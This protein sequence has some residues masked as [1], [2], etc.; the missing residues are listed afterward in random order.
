MFG[1]GLPELIILVVIIGIPVG[2]NLLLR[3]YNK[4]TGGKKMSNV[5]IYKHPT[6]GEESV[7]IGFSWPAFLFTII[8]MLT[9]RL[10]GI[11]AIWVLCV[12]IWSGLVVFMTYPQFEAYQERAKQY[13]SGLP[14]TAVGEPRPGSAIVTTGGWLALFLVPGFKGNAWRR[15]NLM[16]RGYVEVR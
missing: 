6:K 5:K 14:V 10:W 7:K 3:F 4:K 8:W 16:K 12:F 13:Q 2:I 1:I 11:A 9:K 15:R